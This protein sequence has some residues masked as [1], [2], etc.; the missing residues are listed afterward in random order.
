MY[1]KLQTTLNIVN[2]VTYY[3]ELRNVISIYCIS[4]VSPK[5]LNWLYKHSSNINNFT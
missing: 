3:L 2:N 5:K 1:T 4:H